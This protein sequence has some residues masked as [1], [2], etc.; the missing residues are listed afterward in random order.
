[1]KHYCRQ[2]NTLKDNYMLIPTIVILEKL[3]KKVNPKKII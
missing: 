2:L 1:M 3:N